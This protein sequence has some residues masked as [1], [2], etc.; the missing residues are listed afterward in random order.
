MINEA[1]THLEEKEKEL[2]TPSNDRYA[3]LTNPAYKKLPTINLKVGGTE[4]T[5][6]VDSGATESVLKKDSLKPKPKVSGRY[7]K[8]IGATGIVVIEPYTT[9]LTVQHTEGEGGVTF[10]HSFMWSDNCPVN[11][12]G[13]DLMCKLRIVIIANEKGVMSH[14][15]THAHI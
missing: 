15:Q 6:L 8:T 11:L 13:R 7:V 12:L 14:Q 1:I 3:H 4:V 10:K 5:F 9:P 2:S